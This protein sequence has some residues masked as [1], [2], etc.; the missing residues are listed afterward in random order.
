MIEL[1]FACA[2]L[3]QRNAHAHFI[4]TAVIVIPGIYNY[5]S[6]LPHNSAVFF[7]VLIDFDAVRCLRT[8]QHFVCF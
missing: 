4:E 5:Y 2:S 7:L 6:T 8:F 3:G 1:E